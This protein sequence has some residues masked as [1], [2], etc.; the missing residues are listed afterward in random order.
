MRIWFDARRDV[1]ARRA[2]LAVY[3]QCG[4]AVSAVQTASASGDA[5]AAF[6]GRSVRS[7]LRR[8]SIQHS[9]QQR[10]D[11]DFLAA[12]LAS[13]SE[14]R[15]TPSRSRCPAA[16]PET[17]EIL[18]VEVVRRDPVRALVRVKERPLENAFSC[19]ISFP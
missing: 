3:G 10:L 18:A 17:G 16:V 2:P 6:R 11:P 14:A 1:S 4:E 8:T 9:G 7:L 12:R 19:S 13:G 15:V 5:S